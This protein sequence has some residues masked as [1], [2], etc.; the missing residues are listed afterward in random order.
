MSYSLKKGHKG[1]VWY[2]CCN[3]KIIEW[4]Y[5]VK[6]AMKILK[7]Y[8]EKH[9]NKCKCGKEIGSRYTQCNSC[10]KLGMKNNYKYDESISVHGHSL[11]P[12]YKSVVK[13]K[14]MDKSDLNIEDF[15]THLLLV[16][17]TEELTGKMMLKVD[18][19]KPLSLDNYRLNHTRMR[20]HAR[21]T[22]SDTTSQYIGV[23]AHKDKFEA[24]VCGKYIRGS[25]CDTEEESA[26]V[27]DQY[28][29]DNGLADKYRL[30]FPK[31]ETL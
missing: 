10:S 14:S 6:E 18:T 3:D 15:I 27:R 7:Y 5:N 19:D 23:S 24:T 16:H 30:N 28:I 21:K 31:E 8:K 1:D 29:V 20:S 17:T 22:K 11:Y 25:S 12:L 2:I 4:V 26:R 9:M 13:H